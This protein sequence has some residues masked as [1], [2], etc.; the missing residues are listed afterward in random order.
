MYLGLA[1]TNFKEKICNHNKDFNRKQ[2][3]KTREL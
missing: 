3:C 1:E 2:I